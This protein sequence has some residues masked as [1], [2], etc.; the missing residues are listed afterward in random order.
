MEKKLAMDKLQ[1][2]MKAALNKIVQ[3]I[4]VQHKPDQYEK[5]RD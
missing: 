5:R 4:V 3:L 1:N 2:D